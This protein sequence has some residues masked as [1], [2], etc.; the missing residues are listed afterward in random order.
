MELLAAHRVGVAHCPESNMKLASGI[1]PVAA[2]LHQG[3]AVGLGTDGCASNNNLDLLQ[4]LDTAAK[5]QKVH[6]LDPTSLSAPAALGLATRGSARL[7]GLSREVGALTPGRKADLAVVDLDQPHLTPVYNPYS[8]LV[9][10]AT[11]ADVQTV[12]VHGRVLV[13]DRELLAFDLEET[14]ARARELAQRVTGK[15][16]PAGGCA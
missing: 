8:Q 5:L 14:L 11:G 3:V 13:R 2:L 15:P 1:A 10:A 9:Y 7:L 4:E 6:Y 16:L 12:M